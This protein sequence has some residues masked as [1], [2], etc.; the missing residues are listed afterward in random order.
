MIYG[1]AGAGSEA[2]CGV[3][4]LLSVEA[5]VVGPLFVRPGVGHRRI[6]VGG[7]EVGHGVV[8]AEVGPARPGPAWR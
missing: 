1:M 6:V 7:L 8:G 2:G 4:S 5:S 3:G